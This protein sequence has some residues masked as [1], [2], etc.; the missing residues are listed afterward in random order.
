[1]N[2]T[3]HLG[4]WEVSAYGAFTVLALVAGCGL[5][6][7]VA[8]R[9]GMGPR[10]TAATVTAVGLGGLIGA[11]LWAA[12]TA[13]DPFFGSLDEVVEL[14][15]GNMAIFGGLLGTALGGLAAARVARVPV[16]LLADAA[17]PALGVGI[18]LLRTGCL[19]AGCCFG[20]VTGLPWGITYP[21]GSL[22]HGYQAAHSPLVL[23]IGPQ[24][25]HPLPI[26]EM[27]AGAALAVV[28]LVILKRGRRDGM[29]L[30]VVVGGYALVRLLIGP[31]RVPEPGST[32]GW[33][34]PAVFALVAL[35]AGVWLAVPRVRAWW[36]ARAY[37]ASA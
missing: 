18:L 6:G 10:V 27:L 29:A 14:R 34:D 24:P 8:A 26:Y 19:L 7:L 33:F 36:A 4:G 1:M 22:A 37:P 9:R 28:A 11:R 17:A 16:T 2:P 3:L 20:K 23:L 31:L 12:A 32:P 13:A 30:A 15:F 35:T 21:R 5:F 25:V